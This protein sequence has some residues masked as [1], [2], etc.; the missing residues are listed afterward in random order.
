MIVQKVPKVLHLSHGVLVYFLYAYT[1]AAIMSQF[2][3]RRDTNTLI[4]FLKTL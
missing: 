1:M 3:P 4:W 2:Q